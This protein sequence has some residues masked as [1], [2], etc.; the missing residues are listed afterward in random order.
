[1]LS[2]VFIESHNKEAH[3]ELN[4]SFQC[5]TTIDKTFEC[6]RETLVNHEENFGSLESV[7]NTNK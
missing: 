6:L 5:G 4:T 1:M 2:F 3:A 7:L